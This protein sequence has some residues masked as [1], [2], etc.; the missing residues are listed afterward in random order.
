MNNE[1]KVVIIL[2]YINKNML[3][4][5]PPHFFKMQILEHEIHL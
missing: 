1:L 4:H 3:D 2:Q 5:N